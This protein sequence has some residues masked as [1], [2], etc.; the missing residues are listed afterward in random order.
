MAHQA[1]SGWA[2][3][4]LASQQVRQLR[5]IRPRVIALVASHVVKLGHRWSCWRGTASFNVPDD[6]SHEFNLRSG[7]GEKINARKLIFDHHQQLNLIQPVE[8]E[9]VSQVRVTRNFCS[10]NTCVISN[11]LTYFVGVRTAF[12]RGSCVHS[13]PPQELTPITDSSEAVRHRRAVTQIRL[14]ELA[15]QIIMTTGTSGNLPK[16][17]RGVI[18]VSQLAE[19][20]ACSAAG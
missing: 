2:C 3:C 14:C 20:S 4:L 11:E 15:N 13:C 8:A 5:D 18:R 1:Q 12:W 16:D 10:F 6:V 9:I 19:S 7:D 17:C